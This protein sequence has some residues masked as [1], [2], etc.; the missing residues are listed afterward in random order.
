MSY[1]IA[2]GPLQLVT[3][4]TF[5]VRPFSCQQA[6]KGCMPSFVFSIA[7]Q[8]G[9]R[10]ALDHLLICNTRHCATLRR[11]VK[12]GM[13]HKL[14][15][16]FDEEAL[17][18]CVHIQPFLYQETRASNMLEQRNFKVA[19][20]HLARCPNEACAR[21]RRSLLLS[22]RDNVSPNAHNSL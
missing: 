22:I 6:Y 7:G 10:S 20:N 11:K 18:G 9:F 3:E 12:E 19:A 2:I 5:E 17:L 15:W 16:L 14:G 4:N 8:V 21:L 1:S 13:Q